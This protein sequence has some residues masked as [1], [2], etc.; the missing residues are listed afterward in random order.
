M[1]FWNLG[2]KGRTCGIY[3]QWTV[4]LLESKVDGLESG[5][6]PGGGSYPTGSAGSLDRVVEE[7]HGNGNNG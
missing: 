2:T 4:V 7:N 1:L 5:W 3:G 6:T